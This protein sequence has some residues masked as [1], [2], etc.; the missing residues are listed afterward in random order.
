MSRSVRA[1]TRSLP[2][3]E[4]TSSPHRSSAI[5]AS[6]TGTRLTPSRSAVACS[7]IFV[8]AASVPATISCSRIR[9]TRFEIECDRSVLPPGAAG[10]LPA[11]AA[12]RRL[13]GAGWRV[14][15]RGALRA[16]ASFSGG[17]LRR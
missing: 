3:G 1:G 13:E 14:V 9:A 2:V 7:A 6:R 15:R 12:E 11:P 10:A 17:L 8:P 5:A 4:R 16:M